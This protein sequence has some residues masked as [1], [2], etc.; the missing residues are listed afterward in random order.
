MEL[1]RR[2]AVAVDAMESPK[3]NWQHER[4]MTPD[5]FKWALYMMG[6]SRAACARFIGR[7]ERTVYRWWHGKDEIPTAVALLLNG[8]MSHGEK[9]V[10]PSRPRP[11]P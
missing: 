2:A 3:M 11:T 8:M 9:P 1:P 6:M 5:Q 10:V 7:D 4:S